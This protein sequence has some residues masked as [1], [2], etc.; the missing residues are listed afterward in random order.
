MAIPARVGDY[1]IQCGKGVPVLYA[2]QSGSYRAIAENP[3]NLLDTQGSLPGR[4]GF[5]R[6]MTGESML[7][8]T[9]EFWS[10]IRLRISEITG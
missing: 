4:D 9:E 5:G 8:Y 7:H 3:R 6:G 10:R 1:H 2:E